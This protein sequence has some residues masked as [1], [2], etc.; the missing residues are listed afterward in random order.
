MGSQ[1]SSHGHSRRPSRLLPQ[2]SRT[3]RHPASNSAH[4]SVYK[5][6]GD[7]SSL[8]SKEQPPACQGCRMCPSPPE[9]CRGA[10]VTKLGAPC[11]PCSARC[12]AHEDGA[13]QDSLLLLR[14]RTPGSAPGSRSLSV[15][16][17]GWLLL[18]GPLFSSVSGDGGGKT[19]PWDGDPIPKDLPNSAGPVGS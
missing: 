12:P 8:I 18:S 2:F 1:L 5:T 19:K 15:S 7:F 13:L 10:G 17:A 14:P 6:S 11:R 3:D 9:V 4:G 16:T